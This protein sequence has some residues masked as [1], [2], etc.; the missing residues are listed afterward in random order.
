MH[1]ITNHCIHEVLIFKYIHGEWKRSVGRGREG[2]E[3]GTRKGQGGEEEEEGEE[4]KRRKNGSEEER[5]GKVH[6]TVF[7]KMRICTFHLLSRSGN[8]FLCKSAASWERTTVH[9]S[10]QAPGCAAHSTPLVLGTRAQNVDHQGTATKQTAASFST[11][12]TLGVLS[13]ENITE[14]CLLAR[15]MIILRGNNG[16]KI[17]GK[18]ELFIENNTADIGS[19]AQRVLPVT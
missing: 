19:E 9:P 17:E 2:R 12:E 8:G 18:P 4:G 11:Q 5:Q 16:L 13:L 10:A 1:S 7:S 15:H 3:M 6:D 14:W